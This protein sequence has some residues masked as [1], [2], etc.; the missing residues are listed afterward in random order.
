MTAVTETGAAWKGQPVDCPECSVAC[1][2]TVN[3]NTVGWVFP[4]HQ[5]KGRWNCPGSFTAVPG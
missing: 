1:V 5:P 2:P 4:A 3:R